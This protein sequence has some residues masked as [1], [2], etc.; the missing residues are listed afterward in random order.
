MG[1]D[2]DA[3]EADPRLALKV[4]LEYLK[5]EAQVL[6]FLD[7]ARLLGEA[8]RRLETEVPLQPGHC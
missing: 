1:R 8:K 7:V 5:A 2:E 6:G 3:E 4:S